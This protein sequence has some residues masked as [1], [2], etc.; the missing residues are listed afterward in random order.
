MVTVV[1][2]TVP[3]VIRLPRRLRGLAAL[4][5]LSLGGTALLA[6][7]P[8]AA[9]P[10]ADELAL[11]LAPDATTQ[12]NVFIYTNAHRGRAG[13]APVRYSGAAT[14]AAQRHANDMARRNRM[15]HIGS[16]GSNAGQR[17]TRA[18]FRWTSWGENL[19]VGYTSSSAVVWAWLNS[20]GHRANLL[21]PRFR[22][23]GVGIAYGHGR[24][25]WC[26]VLASS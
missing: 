5:A 1:A 10:V 26:V 6:S 20:P 25:W 24:T 18:G 3:A 2:M 7:A 19:A 9:V 23:M 11:A 13:A 8:A 12:Q 16:D 15:T 4:L 17:L 14:V 22:W 21:N